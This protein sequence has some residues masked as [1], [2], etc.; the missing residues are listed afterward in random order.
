MV[1]RVLHT[2][3]MKELIEQQWIASLLQSFIIGV[4]ALIALLILG[5]ALGVVE[6][7]SPFPPILFKLFKRVLRFAVLILAIYLILESWGFE[8]KTVLAILGT[9]L[10]MVAIGFV[11]VWSLLSNLMCA[12]ILATFRPFRVGDIIEI[13]SE[14]VQGKVTDLTLLFTT[15][16][17]DDGDDFQVPNNTFF[18][19]I[20]R[21]RKGIKT[22]ELGDQLLQQNPAES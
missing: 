1:G 20:Y 4:I 9:V 8:L 2:P 6:R 13:P 10:G 18:Q 17:T 7:K 21:R 19:K 3:Q 12:F 15:L 14:G 11:A 16:Q 22:S 5:R